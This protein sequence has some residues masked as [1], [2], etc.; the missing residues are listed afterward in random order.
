MGIP[1]S[2]PIGVVEELVP[3]TVESNEEKRVIPVSNSSTHT[4]QHITS[5]EIRNCLATL[6]YY[7]VLI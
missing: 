7:W 6:F 4:E 1:V 5:I 2:N 3:N